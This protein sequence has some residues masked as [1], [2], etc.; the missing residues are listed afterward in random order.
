[1]TALFSYSLQAGIYVLFGYL[2]YSLAAA[3]AMRPR[4]S[5]MLLWAI[6]LTSLLM[7]LCPDLCLFTPSVT[8][9]AADM[10]I[11]RPEVVGIGASTSLSE[12]I[13]YLPTL[14][15]VGILLSLA[16]MISGIIR[17]VM[18]IGKGRKERRGPITLVRVDRK[19]SPF[20]WMGYVFIGKDDDSLADTEMIL[21]H[22]MAHIRRRHSLDLALAGLICALMW[23]NPAVWLWRRQLAM[24]HEYEADTD[25]VTDGFDMKAYQILLIKKAVGPRLQ[26]LANNLTHSKLKKRITMMSKKQSKRGALVRT[27]A[28]VPAI[29]GALA[30]V[31]IPA[32]ASA[33]DRFS[34]AEVQSYGEVNQ[35]IVV[36]Q[37]SAQSQT[38]PVESSAADVLPEYPGGFDA[39][40]M[41]LIKN[42]KYP[43]EAIKDGIEGK[44]VVRFTVK[45]DG[46]ISDVSVDKPI[47]KA[48]DDEAIRVVKSMPKWT[49]SRKDGRAV[50]VSM[51]LPIT[52]KLPPVKPKRGK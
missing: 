33:L 39:Q 10:A 44:V 19:M 5:R 42:I 26:S 28:V 29:V 50:D 15:M 17:L 25:V 30:V 14:Y 38:K 35:N 11:G 31:N 46:S 22:E 51:A 4:L 49:P 41:F 47:N 37:A 34:P 18:L 12:F 27:L 40:M 36:S 1:M 20:S 3:D 24:V 52:F 32:V 9:A 6:M 45:S 2:A 7:P 16:V 13:K 48:L 23:Y 43:A 21:S 8:D